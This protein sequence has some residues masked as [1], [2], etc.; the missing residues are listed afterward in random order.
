MNKPLRVLLVED[1]PDDAELVRRQLRKAGF[2]ACCAQ[3]DNEADYLAHLTPAVD[4]VLSDFDLPQF[5][6]PRAMELLRRK[7][8]CWSAW[9]H[10][11]QACSARPLHRSSWSSKS[12]QAM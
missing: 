5:S 4:I 11:S 3:V 2:A 8:T 9:E 10:S 7:R 1:N 6:A 12:V